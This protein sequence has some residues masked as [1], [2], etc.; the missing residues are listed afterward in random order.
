MNAELQTAPYERGRVGLDLRI[1]VHDG[2]ILLDA[3]EDSAEAA[4]DS[5]TF[6]R[7]IGT[8]ELSGE[9]ENFQGARYTAVSQQVGLAL[10][11]EASL[12]LR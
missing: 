1:G 12:E 2:R 3:L 4:G 9:C 7:G 11:R 8:I 10:V 5:T 6:A